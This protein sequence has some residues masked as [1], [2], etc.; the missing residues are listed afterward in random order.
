MLKDFSD[1]FVGLGRALNVLLGTD[2]VLDLSC[3]QDV[4]ATSHVDRVRRKCRK[5]L[6]M[7][8]LLLSNGGLRGL[9]QLL[10]GLGVVSQILLAANKD[11]GKTLAEMKDLGDPLKQPCVSMRI[12]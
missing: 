6:A 9:V 1:T 11:D 8:Y 3:L 4:S 7:T 5:R 10:D 12:G 2:L